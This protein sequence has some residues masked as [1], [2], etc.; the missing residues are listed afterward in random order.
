M[1]LRNIALCNLRIA[2]V[3]VRH[4]RKAP[5]ISDILPSVRAR[6]VLQ[7]LLV[8]PQGD[9]FEI[10]AGRRRY[11]AASKVAEEQGLP[12]DN[13]LLP[14]AVTESGSDAD[15]LEASLIENVARAPM[16]EL[17]EY[18][19]FAKLLKQGKTVAD[20]AQTFGQTERYIKQRLALAGLNSTIKEAY[21]SGDIEPE[22]LQVLASATRSQ[23]KD[24]VAAFEAE[25]GGDGDADGAPRGH[26]L[27]QWLFGSEQIAT[28]AAL[29]P[30]EAYKGEI[31]ADLFGDSSY[32][33]DSAGFWTLQNAAIASLRDDRVAKGWK[34]TVLD[35]GARFPSWQYDEVPLEDGGEAFIE[36]RNNGEVEVHE[37]YRP[38]GETCS[39]AKAEETD[40]APQAARPELTKAAENYLALHRHAVVRAELLAH[41]DI[42]LRLA[43]AHMIGS[44]PLWS[45]KPDPQRADKETTSQSVAA[46]PAQSALNSE[47]DAVLE[48][49]QVEKSY[50]GTVTRGNG[51]GFTA[52][53]LFARLLA[54][55]EETVLRILALVMAETL[56]AG[57]ILTEAAGLAIKPDVTRWWKLDDVFLDLLKDRTAIN[58]LLSEIAGKA[59]AD[60]N[61]SEP[62]KVQKKIIHDCLNGEGRERAEG[63]V[64]RYMTFPIGHYDPNKTLEIARA[65]ENINALFTSI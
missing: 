9:A 7:P 18:E 31:V 4:G 65:S 40:G 53:S 42:A 14:C 44:S 55:P 45:V 23:Q 15:A 6:G 35:K 48:L 2:N 30:L 56:A 8:R 34:V 51:D 59:V 50:F 63:F 43:V 49:L 36:V 58:A 41:P 38:Y 27:K 54:L 37:G 47:R 28:T 21:R 22:E 62:G 1:E 13:V 16:D 19:A 60:A 10:V 57:S 64:P 12:T 33:A 26:Q 25:N 5:D 24:W 52:V 29:F 3:N 46:S 17:Q 39:A 32:F 11:F 20:I 61:L